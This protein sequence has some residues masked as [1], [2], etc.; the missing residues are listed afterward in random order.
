MAVQIGS[1]IRDYCNEHHIAVA[2]LCKKLGMHNTTVYRIFKCSDINTETL[3]LLSSALGHNFFQYFMPEEPKS[4]GDEILKLN[5]EMLEIK[6]QLDE[7]NK[8]IEVL[9]HDN[10]LLRR[11]NDLL[12]QFF[13]KIKPV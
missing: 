3:I 2:D 6:Q 9:R 12:H 10:E 4:S 5:T 1:I 8:A 11:E 13:E 7:T